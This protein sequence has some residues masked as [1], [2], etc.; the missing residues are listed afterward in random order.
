MYRIPLVATDSAYLQMRVHM[1]TH[2]QTK[3]IRTPH[4]DARMQFAM[5]ISIAA[6]VR[7][8]QH[9]ATPDLLPLLEKFLIGSRVWVYLIM[10]FSQVVEFSW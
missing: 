2:S 6:F 1:W 4:T 8:H 7:R 10:L 5:S 3:S 9:A